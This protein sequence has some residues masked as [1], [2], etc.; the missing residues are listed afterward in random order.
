MQRVTNSRRTVVCLAA[1]A[2]TACVEV[3]EQW[4]LG[5]KGE[6]TYALQ[7]AWD[8]DLWRR[9]RQ[10]LGPSAARTLTKDRPMPLRAQQ[11]RDSLRGLPG[12]SLLG[13]DEGQ[14]DAGRRALRI[15]L[16]FTSLAA[17]WRWEPMAGRA[18]RL[19][20]DE[21]RSATWTM[22]PFPRL[23]VLD[24]TW[25]IR[26]ALARDPA[27]A[28]APDGLMAGWHADRDTLALVWQM[29]REPLARVSCQVGITLQ[30]PI[31]RSQGAGART[32]GRRATFRWDGTMLASGT[33]RDVSVAWQV[34]ELDRVPAIRR[35][36]PRA[37]PV[38]G[39][40]KR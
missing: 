40:G 29:V 18:I 8:A 3:D 15:R 14:D 32:E 22:R 2:L 17:L 21:S 31:E 6:G 4:T 23:P 36:L 34:S 11:V 12:L 39:G 28:S 27:Y 35:R 19:T 20:V 9:V 25:A 16:S 5:A 37:G 33:G 1:L 13:C 24:R 7:L 10:A 26:R 30:S 38:T